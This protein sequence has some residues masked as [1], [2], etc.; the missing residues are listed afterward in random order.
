[1]KTESTCRICKTGYNLV[2]G[3]CTTT[4]QGCLK[5]IN[6]SGIVCVQC[7]DNYFLTAAKTCV[8]KASN[9]LALSS[10]CIEIDSTTNCACQKCRNFYQYG[11][12][13]QTKN[14]ITSNGVYYTSQ[15]CSK[16]QV[17]LNVVSCAKCFFNTDWTDEDTYYTFDYVY[18]DISEL[19]LVEGQ[20]QEGRYPLD[21]S[22]N[23][24]YLNTS[25]FCC[26]QGQAQSGS[27]CVDLVQSNCVKLDNLGK[28]S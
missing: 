16:Y 20:L 25:N 7:D 19:N 9:C 14:A 23:L 3:V 24:T 26:L 17:V 4:I 2:S 28:C 1:M 10:N 13:C 22:F 18:P 8:A 21:A 11:N 15:Y 12:D 5:V 27:T 6:S